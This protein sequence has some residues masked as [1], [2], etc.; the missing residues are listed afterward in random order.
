[1]W[2]DTIR[3]TLR[4]EVSHTLGM[5]YRLLRWF[6]NRRDRYN[7]RLGPVG[8]GRSRAQ[9]GYVAYTGR[10]PSSWY[11]SDHDRDRNQY[12]G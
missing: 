1:M 6:T 5:L 12:T 7:T 10:I 8:A 4:D 3:H 2:T 11:L 9:L